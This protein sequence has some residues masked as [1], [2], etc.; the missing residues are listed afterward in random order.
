MRS[1]LLGTA[2]VCLVCGLTPY[3]DFVIANTYLI[4]N[5]LPVVVVLSF[6]I[7]T[8]VINGPLC[9]WK[10]TSALSS[11][12]LGIVL[13]MM[14]VSCGLPSQGLFRLFLPIPVTPFHFGQTDPAFFRT[15]LGMHLPHWLFPVSDQ[16][17]GTFNPVVQGFYTHIPGR[18]VPYGAWVVPL[19]GWGIFIAAM[20]GTFV[21]LAVLLRPQWAINERLAFPIAQIELALI[22]QPRPGKMLNDLLGSRLFW[23]A[24]TAVFAIHNVNV[25]HRYYPTTV[26]GIPL[27]YGLGRF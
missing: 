6:F 4:G 7:L 12:E 23:I 18:P 21:A 16:A 20:L 10:P 24:L 5:Y 11:G 3:N 17:K 8:V 25:L 2:G 1:L 13:L 22:E 26:P 14:L 15:F 19:L 27:S 9:R